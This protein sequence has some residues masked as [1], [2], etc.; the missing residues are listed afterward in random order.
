VSVFWP[1]STS[2][3]AIAAAATAAESILFGQLPDGAALRLAVDYLEAAR[4]ISFGGK[5]FGGHFL[6]A[7]RVGAMETR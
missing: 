3:A 5:E 6:D 4:E 7:H 1:D 2:F